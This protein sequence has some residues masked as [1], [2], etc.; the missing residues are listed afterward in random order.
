MNEEIHELG[1]GN[2][3]AQ[4][5]HVHSQ[6]QSLT[7]DVKNLTITVN[8]LAKRNVVMEKLIMKMAEKQDISVRSY[9]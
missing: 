2:S 5:K 8:E 1:E 9:I 4:I 3:A 7:M 6:T